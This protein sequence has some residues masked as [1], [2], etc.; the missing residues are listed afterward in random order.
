MKRNTFFPCQMNEAVLLVTSYE[1]GQLRGWL[2]HPRMETPIEVLSV[3]HL[4][5]SIDDHMLSEARMINP[6]AFQPTGLENLQRQ[7]TLRIRIL[8]QENHTWQGLLRWEERGKEASF[9][10]IWELIQILDEVLSN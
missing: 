5:F 10:S 8:F 4:L 1:N 9:R 6:N 2:S 3:P 7:A